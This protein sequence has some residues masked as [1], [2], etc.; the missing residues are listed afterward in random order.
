VQVTHF[1]S[2]LLNPAERKETTQI[3]SEFNSF[4]TATHKKV[5][6]CLP[7]RVSNASLSSPGQLGLGITY[8]PQPFRNRTT[9]TDQQSREP[10]RTTQKG[11]W[12]TQIFHLSSQEDQETELLITPFNTS[13]E[14]E[15]VKG[16]LST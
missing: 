5:V 15:E 10:E 9:N 4:P 16:G 3:T 1:D 14:Q 8:P 13:I 6:L 11:D 2:F 7:D 12:E